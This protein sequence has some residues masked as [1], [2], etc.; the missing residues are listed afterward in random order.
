MAGNS[1][2]FA[3]HVL[4]A[5]NSNPDNN[6]VEPSKEIVRG[7]AL[8]AAAFACIIHSVSRRGGIWL[9]NFFACVKVGILLAILALAIMIGVRNKEQQGLGPSVVEENFKEAFS[10]PKLPPG[11]A[12]CESPLGGR[13]ENGYGRAFLSI[14]EFMFFFVVLC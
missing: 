5:A 4:K 10:P 9:S 1:I 8:A 11:L 14:S 7:V 6:G 12:G 13:S 2:K 3:V